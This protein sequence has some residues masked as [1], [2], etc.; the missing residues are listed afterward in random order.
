MPAPPAP[1]GAESFGLAQPPDT[2]V[3]RTEPR[4]PART[5]LIVAGIVCA[6]LLLVAGATAFLHRG[7]GFPA[8]IG[9]LPRMH[10]QVAKDFE[11]AIARAES[12]G[13]RM[14]G[15]M[16]GSNS[17]VPELIVERFDGA[18]V[19]SLQDTPDAFFDEVARGFEST[20]NTTVDTTDKAAQTIDAVYYA[21]A[22][23]HPSSTTAGV[24]TDGALCM[25]EGEDIGIV[26]TLRTSDPTSA[27]A[28]VQATY[29][30]M[31]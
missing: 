21:C 13:V 11:D 16:Y 10:T 24:S 12:G 9:G 14:R 22:S 27:I 19:S 30:A 18:P 31:H 2:L 26:V 23:V 15:A 6:A 5:P 28:D 20:S 4:S 17:D 7:D 25:W 3:P 29:V 8:T 1:A